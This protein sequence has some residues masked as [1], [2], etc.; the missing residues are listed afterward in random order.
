MS[1]I[2]M[3]ASAFK[4]LSFFQNLSVGK[5]LNVFK[6]IPGLHMCQEIYC[7]TDS[8]LPIVVL[9]VLFRRRFR[10]LVPQ[11]GFC[12]LNCI[13]IIYAYIDIIKLSSS[14]SSSS[15]LNYCVCVS[16]KHAPPFANRVIDF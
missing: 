3:S 10:I 7:V 14:S 15:S 16:G 12:K 6:I 1:W 4:S 8:T 13:V 9:V 11:K 5:N 2:R